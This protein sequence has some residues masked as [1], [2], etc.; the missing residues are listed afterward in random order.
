MPSDSGRGSNNINTEVVSYL[1]LEQGC[2]PEAEALNGDSPVKYFYQYGELTIIKYCIKFKNHD[3][4]TWKCHTR[5]LSLTLQCNNNINEQLDSLHHT[6]NSTV[7]IKSPLH[8]ACS[9]EGS[10][11]VV[12]FL[13][14][15]YDL[16]P[17][18]RVKIIGSD[19]YYDTE[20]V[21]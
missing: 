2:D 11:D 5:P 4:K 10:L 8:L 16:D 21:L 17:L 19:V 1:I 3:L 20:G 6:Q 7:I 9:E 15:E 18:E 14:E 12:K 13:V